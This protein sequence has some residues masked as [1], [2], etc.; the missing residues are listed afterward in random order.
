MGSPGC[1][2]ITIS[3]NYE[4]LKMLEG[5]TRLTC[6]PF[7]SLL[8]RGGFQKNHLYSIKTVSSNRVLQNS[9]G[10]VT[11]KRPI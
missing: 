8:G 3:S 1:E 4:P 6:L 11:K 9:I 5:Y 10:M 2:P 7:K